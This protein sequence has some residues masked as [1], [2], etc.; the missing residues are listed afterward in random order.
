MAD[1]EIKKIQ[2]NPALLRVPEKTRKNRRV[3]NTDGEAAR[4]S[5]KSKQT[6]MNHL[7]RQILQKLRRG[8]G[9]MDGGESDD[10]V[11]P[12][13][14]DS[15]EF[16]KSIEYF[17]NLERSLAP[18]HGGAPAPPSTTHAAPAPALIDTIYP[19][20]PFQQ[21]NNNPIEN[22]KQQPQY[23]CLKGG[24][25]PT[26]KTAAQTLRTAPTAAPVFYT[27]APVAGG[28]GTQ[29]YTPPNIYSIAPV[30]APAHT[31]PPPIPTAAQT[32]IHGGASDAI[33]KYEDESTA[34]IRDY[35]AQRTTAEQYA[36]IARKS[37]PAQKRRI[38]KRTFHVGKSKIHPHVS[39]LL[40]NKTI[41]SR[42]ITEKQHYNEIPIYT[43]KQFLQKKGLIKIGSNSPNHVLRSMYENAML[44][45]GDVV[46]HNKQTLLH[47]FLGGGET[48]SQ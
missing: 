37:V 45:G 28:G 12:I 43:I 27:A 15:S 14:T 7:K 39:V 40:S 47:N 44:L 48:P 25:L 5:E 22:L 32:P 38:T 23:G 31:P 24:T 17:R 10:D 20:Q 41:R 1:N 9:N 34:R 42:I 35:I 16:D 2:L 26:Y 36:G 19:I 11:I 4:S 3:R 18:K 46:N 21:H 30:A 6:S 8:G 13:N 33:K 29:F